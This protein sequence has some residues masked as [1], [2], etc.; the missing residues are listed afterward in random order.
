MV[1][2]PDGTLE[3]YRFI[4]HDGLRERVMRV[5]S[6]DHG[7]SW[8]VP[9][10]VAHIP[11]EH[12]LWG[13][14]TALA[15]D[16]GEVHLAVM[17]DRFSGV[18]G[19]PPIGQPV[20]T[21]GPSKGRWI[22]V[23]HIRSSARRT[24]W[25]SPERIW[26]GFTGSIN[27]MI[28]TSDG[29]IV[30]PF[31]GA[32]GHTWN[33]RASGMDAFH[34]HGSE[35]TVVMYSD[36]RGAS[37]HQGTG[38]MKVWAPITGFGGI[39]PVVIELCDGRVWMLIRTQTGRLYESYSLDG[40]E[41]ST[42]GPTRIVSSDSPVGLVRLS[43]GRMVLL[44]NC[45]QRFAYAY[46]GRHV[47]HAAISEDEGGTWRGRREV[48]RDPCRDEP[49]PESGDFGTAYPAPIVSADDSV[50]FSTGQGAGR[51]MTLRLDPDWLYETSQS[52]NFS[53]GLSEWSVFGTRGV[54]LLPH[55]DR[56]GAQAL[57]ICK[58]VPG[59]TAAAVW[60]F[61]AGRSG[62][63][64]MRVRA[65]MGVGNFRISLSDHFSTPFDAQDEFHSTFNL[66]IAAG[67][68][69]SSLG[70]LEQDAWHDMEM[71]WDT[72]NERQ[73]I[74]RVDGHIVATLAQLHSTDGVNYLRV[75]STADSG[76]AAGLWLAA[77]AADVQP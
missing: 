45:C 51:T 15:D 69:I 61:P 40:A 16:E 12:G 72:V 21:T 55:P 4:G 1:R 37:W 24:R 20:T 54:K 27:S 13:S 10:P 50:V 59:A 57:R 63:I 53:E 74:V 75:V 7:H 39:E 38:D 26:E 9:E 8:S 31:A 56:R 44:W 33:R 19:D 48:A 18:F 35:Q 2:L 28:Q 64:A 46:G 71:I 77:V 66:D 14:I 52:C 67:G 62:S 76:D 43:D 70:G 30:L 73:C 22:D 60:N 3:A 29:R 23:W 32:T 42:P 25:S 11:P 58:Q 6:L 49:P 41:W 65:N 17:N 36:D 34:F 47:L 68:G 5:V